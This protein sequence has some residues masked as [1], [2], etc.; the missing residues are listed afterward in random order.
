MQKWNQLERKKAL[1]YQSSAKILGQSSTCTGLQVLRLNFAY[2]FK[3][4]RHTPTATRKGALNCC[5]QK[6]DKISG[7]VQ[8]RNIEKKTQTCTRHHVH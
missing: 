7:L 1:L 8:P 6:G 5:S 3:T 4:N 2:T